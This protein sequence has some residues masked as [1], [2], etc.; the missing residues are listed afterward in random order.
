MKYRY[1]IFSIGF[2]LLD[3][4]PVPHGDFSFQSEVRGQSDRT[5]EA[6]EEKE[7]ISEDGIVHL[8]GGMD[9]L[10]LIKAVSEINEE[11]YIIDSS[12]KPKDVRIITPEGGMRKEDLL[13]LF[14]T[15]LRLNGLA[16]IKSD[17]V[18]KVINSG[19][20]SGHGTPVETDN[21]D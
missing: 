13:I 21:K 11:T 6:S 4:L 19:D 20:I 12:V 9:I 16:V 3:I 17:G 1:F 10:D 14:D 15:V 7:Y 8:P 2:L 18:N 5:G